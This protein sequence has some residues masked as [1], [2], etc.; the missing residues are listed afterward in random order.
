MNSLSK[1]VI[2]KDIVEHPEN[3]RYLL[4]CQSESNSRPCQNFSG[5]DIKWVLHTAIFT[6]KSWGSRNWICEVLVTCNN[7]PLFINY[8]ETAQYWA[9]KI[10]IQM[11]ARALRYQWFEKIR[12]GTGLWFYLY[13]SPARRP[14]GNLFINLSARYRLNGLRGLEPLSWKN[15]SSLAFCFAT[16]SWNLLRKNSFLSNRFVQPPPRLSA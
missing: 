4:R 15:S 5:T 3:Y 9:A 13:C 12:H 11:A 6:Q 7:F 10:S 8:F 1:T 2:S 14:K 16:K